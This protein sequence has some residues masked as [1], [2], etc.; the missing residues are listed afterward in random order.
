MEEVYENLLT[1]NRWFAE[2]RFTENGLLT[3]GSDPYEAKFG[4]ELEVAGINEWQGAAWESG[5][6]NSPMAIL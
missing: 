5:L 4:Y 3:W 1:W 6:D 2:H